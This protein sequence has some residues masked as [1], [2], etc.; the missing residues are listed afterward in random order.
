MMRS[1]DET[2]RY[3][4]GGMFTAVSAPS[5]QHQCRQVQNPDHL[6][7]AKLVMMLRTAAGHWDALGCAGNLKV[8]IYLVDTYILNAIYVHVRI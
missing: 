1:A 7:L 3:Q 8:G 4:E 5:K 6:S 2:L